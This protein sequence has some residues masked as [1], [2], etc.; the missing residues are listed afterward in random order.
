MGDPD[1]AE[2]RLDLLEGLGELALNADVRM[3][4]KL[5]LKRKAVP[6]NARTDAVHIAIAAVHG[7]D[8]LL[9]W[10]CKHINNAHTRKAING[11]CHEYGFEPPIIC[12]PQEIMEGG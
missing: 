7:V 3:L 9:T 11:V 4:S 6:E 1:A 2:R 12:T 8:Y 10:N 5:L